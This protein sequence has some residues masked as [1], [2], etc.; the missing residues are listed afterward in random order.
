MVDGLHLWVLAKMDTKMLSNY[1]VLT[2]YLYFLNN[3]NRSCTFIMY[4]ILNFKAKNVRNIAFFRPDIFH[5]PVHI[6]KN[7]LVYKKFKLQDF[8]NCRLK[9]CKDILR[10]KKKKKLK[11]AVYIIME[12][13]HCLKSLHFFMRPTK[14]KEII[15]GLFRTLQK[16]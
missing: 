8:L 5:F 4:P 7:F 16:V 14:I 1:S 2:C 3:F 6:N 15:C 12:Q 10:K 13:K 9:T 11:T